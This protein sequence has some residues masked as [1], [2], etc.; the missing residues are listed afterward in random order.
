MKL[1]CTL[2][3]SH[4]SGLIGNP[5]ELSIS[6]PP[7]C[8]GLELQDAVSRK[9]GARTLTAGGS[10][11]AAMTVGVP[12]LVAGVVLVDENVAG[13]H[14]NP[15]PSSVGLML[16]VHGGPGA[17]TVVPLGRGSVRIGRSG[18]EIHIA[19]AELSREHARLEVSEANITIT[20]LGSVNGTT[21]DGKRVRSSPVFTNSLIR[22]GHSTLS[23]V[24][25][26]SGE[27]RVCAESGSHV[28]E[29]LIVWR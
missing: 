22:C 27:Q 4:G 29:P 10:P 25:C 3:R 14:R 17:G 1:E 19:D 7:G 13:I 6:A 26:G 28:A 8:T 9:Y 11:I 12:P 24:L 16:A 15:G 20:D 5:L 2:V 18:T 23:I 21:V